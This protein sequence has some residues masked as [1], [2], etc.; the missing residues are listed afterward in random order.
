[1]LHNAPVPT[2]DVNIFQRDSIAALRH[3]HDPYGIT[4]PDIY[5]DLDYYG[6]G[7]SVD[8][9]LQFGFPYPP[10]S[11]LLAT[12]GE[13][14]GDHR[15]AQLAAMEL[16]ALL[17]T[18]A[19]PGGAGL[20]AAALYLT[21]PRTFFVLH[22]AWT[23]PFVVLG[24]SAVVF[25][26]CRSRKA[27]SSWFGAFIALKQYLVLGLPAALLLLPWPLTR[28]DLQR[29]AVRSAGVALAVTLPFVLWNPAGFWKSVVTLQFYQP[30]REDSLSYL[31]WWAVLGHERPPA[32]IAFVAMAI[33][34]AVAVWRFPRTPAG[35]GAALSLTFFAFFAF[36]K[37]AFC[38]YYMLVIGGLCVALAA[39]RYPESTG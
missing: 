21:T 34:A 10:L 18:F 35:F 15:F 24:L 37:Q 19:R 39:W 26:A 2:I 12:P 27:A 16:S 29:F 11:L 5:A 7:L 8:G 31:A 9:R 13:F 22:Q 23:E 6:T 30:F 3:G 1:V 25:A 17:M 28:G 33:A 20:I 36:N 4:F 14:F 32:F 38:N